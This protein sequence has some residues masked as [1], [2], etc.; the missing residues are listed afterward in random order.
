MPRHMR[1]LV[2]FLLLSLAAAPALAH[3]KERVGDRIGLF[4][5]A[6]LTFP[7]GEPFHIAHG[8]AVSPEEGASPPVP[9]GRFDFR[10]DIDGTYMRTDFVERTVTSEDGGPPSFTL[11][12]VYNFPQGMSGTHVFTGHWYAPCH[13]AVQVG[14]YPGPCTNPAQQVETTRSRIVTFE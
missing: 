7:A 1:I 4:S 3:G 13:Y 8:H 9:I 11:I 6:P 14:G 2:P 10:L 5:P 12:W